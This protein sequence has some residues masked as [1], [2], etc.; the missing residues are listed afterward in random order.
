MLLCLLVVHGYAPL[1]PR[2]SLLRPATIAMSSSSPSAEL[3][4]LAA[5]TDKT[6]EDRERILALSRELEDIGDTRYLDS[7]TLVGNYEVLYYDRS[8]DGGR[9]NGEANKRRQ[10]GLR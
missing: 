7:P 8:V 5:I 9:D 6:A 4:A 1:G 2:A 10:G 3:A